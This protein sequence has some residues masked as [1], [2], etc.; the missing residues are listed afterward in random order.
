MASDGP[1]IVLTIRNTGEKVPII[2]TPI[3]IAQYLTNLQDPSTK[4]LDKLLFMIPVVP[5]NSF[6]L[7]FSQLFGALSSLLDFNNTFAAFAV[8]Q[9]FNLTKIYSGPFTVPTPQPGAT[10][11]AV[12]IDVDGDTG[13]VTNKSTGSVMQSSYSPQ[14]YLEKFGWLAAVVLLGIFAL[15]VVAAFIKLIVG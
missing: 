2:V 10:S 11:V 4:S 13:K 9:H 12:E 5:Q 6:T 14:T 1:N 8:D 7:D 15:F 3:S